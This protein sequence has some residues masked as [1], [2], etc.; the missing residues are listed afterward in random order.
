MTY[1]DPANHV[2]QVDDDEGKDPTLCAL[3]SCDAKAH[4]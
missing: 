4:A 2:F 3:C 1:F